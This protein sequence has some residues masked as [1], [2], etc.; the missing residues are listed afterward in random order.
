M[1]KT[2]LTL[3][4]TSVILSASAILVSSCN[5]RELDEEHKEKIAAPRFQV[6]EH[7][8]FDDLRRDGRIMLD[9]ETGIK[10]LYVPTQHNDG[11]IFTRLWEK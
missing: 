11:P 7:V 3:L 9:K 2:N 5:D 10:Y 6:V 1:N 8:K 4:T